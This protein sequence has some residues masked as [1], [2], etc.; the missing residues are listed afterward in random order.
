MVTH[1]LVASTASSDQGFV[2]PE[3]TYTH[4]PNGNLIDA[5]AGPIHTVDNVW[6]PDRDVLDIKENKVGITT[7]SK[8]NYTVNELGQRTTVSQT[9]T[10][11]AAARGIILGYDALGQVT[12][13]DHSTDDN[14]DR[15]YQYD[16]IGNRIEARYGVA[17]VTGTP[18]YTANALNQYIAVGSLSP[19]MDDDG[20]A[21]SYPLPVAPTTNS[22]LAWDAENRLV[23]AQVGTSGPLVRNYYDAQSRRIAR[24]VAGETTISLYDGW[25]CI[26]EY[27]TTNNSSINIHKS[28][29]WG[30]DLSGSF[31]GAG[32]VGGLLA[33]TI[34][35]PQSTIY[36]PTDDG[37]GN[38][39]EYLDSTGAATAH[40]EYDPF[41]NTVVNTDTAG[42][43]AY[44]FS[45]KPIDHA[46]GIYYYGYRWY[47]PLTGR[48]PS[49]DPQGENGGIELYSIN[50]NDSINKYDYLGWFNRDKKTSN[51]CMERDYPDQYE[52]Y[53]K[54][55]DGGAKGHGDFFGSNI[56]NFNAP[57]D[58]AWQIKQKSGKNRDWMDEMQ[59]HFQDHDAV[60]KNVN[61]A[62]DGC[63]FSEFQDSMHY[64]QD[65][66]V[67]RGYRPS[68]TPKDSGDGG[69]RYSEG[70]QRDGRTKHKCPCFDSNGIVRGGHLEDYYI[71]KK[72]Q[73]TPDF[74]NAAWDDANRETMELVK[75][76]LSKCP[77][78]KETKHKI[79][80]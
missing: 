73:Y 36:Y 44:R 5:V 77:N 60:L 68:E 15:A 43:F 31:Q 28:F 30:I 4:V 23:E 80:K 17:T 6:K 54:D 22:T 2:T 20:N 65:S 39:S 69:V 34:H 8:Y 66:Y 49:R 26:A 41:G 14:F 45:T 46:A 3:F 79:P 70:A 21:T 7:V 1:E 40:F 58:R 72:D 63:K 35:D 67:H 16:A 78:L 52:Q 75:K 53:L 59:K 12:S 61:A 51:E 32:G 62:I 42:Q 18:N 38:V 57:D 24:T 27:S 64:L 11:F 33:A 9:G 56:F 10:A 13:A 55:F 74:N 76:F 37:N 25:N 29:L 71:P 50:N 48:W 47:D 19:V